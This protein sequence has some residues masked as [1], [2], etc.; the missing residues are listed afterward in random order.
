MKTEKKTR[1]RC[2][3]DFCGKRNWSPSHMTRHEKGCT[4]NPN[5]KCGICGNYGNNPQIPMEDLL[6][7]FDNARILP[8][9]DGGFSHLDY[10]YDIVARL[11]EMTD[12]CHACM[13]AAIRQFCVKNNCNPEDSFPSFKYKELRGDFWN[14]VNEAALSRHYG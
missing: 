11:H 1:F 10:D 4:M 5:R 9:F 6:G 8:G 7:A 14:A 12:G 3:C 2:T 13:L